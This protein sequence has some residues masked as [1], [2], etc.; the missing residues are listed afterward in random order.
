[1]DIKR[2]A[3]IRLICS[4]RCLRQS[5]RRDALKA[6]RFTKIGHPDHSPDWAPIGFSHF[7]KYKMVLRGLSFPDGIEMK[8][9]V[10]N[11]FWREILE[12]Y[13]CG[14]KAFNSPYE[15]C[16]SLEVDIF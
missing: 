4:V 15:K 13:F 2:T 7:Y 3:S 11:K 16:I 14:T 1:M 8:S 12:I 10:E 6:T 5:Y 9:V